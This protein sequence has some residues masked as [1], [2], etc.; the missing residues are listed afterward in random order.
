MYNNDLPTRAELPSSKQLLRSTF[1]AFAMA[2]V[3]LAAVVL[4]SEYGIDP[5]GLG[6][7]LGLTEMGE[8]KTA[9]AREAALQADVAPPPAVA[10][11]A[12]SAAV[13]DPAKA[14]PA[15]ATGAGE[16]AAPPPPVEVANPQRSDELTFKLAPGAAAEIKVAMEKNATV[17]YQWSTVGGAVNFDNHGDSPSIAYFGYSKGR[18]VRADEGSIKAAFDGKHGWYWRN[19]TKKEVTVTLSTQGDYRSFLRII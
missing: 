6:G 12:Q 13:A 14:A 16:P 17:R 10:K 15:V 2:T 4:P 1:I 5:T 9:L 8:I 11:P 19:R 18:S 7:V 3:L